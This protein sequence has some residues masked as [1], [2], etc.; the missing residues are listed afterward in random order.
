MLEKTE[1]TIGNEQ[2]S[3]TGNIEH[4]TKRKK[5]KKNPNKK[6]HKNTHRKLK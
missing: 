6:P 5:P 1:G 4:S 2:Y 3:D